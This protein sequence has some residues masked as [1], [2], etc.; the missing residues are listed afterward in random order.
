MGS[1]LSKGVQAGRALVGTEALSQANAH[2][3]P[4]P[5][6]LLSGRGGWGGSQGMACL[7]AAAALV[8]LL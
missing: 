1:G 3:L 4:G 7:L 2:L 8:V 6:P 5:H